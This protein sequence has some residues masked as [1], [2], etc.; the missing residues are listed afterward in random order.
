MFRTRLLSGIVLVII[1]AIMNICGGYVMG[2]VLIPVA[3]QGLFEFY[4]SVGVTSTDKGKHGVHEIIGYIGAVVYFIVSYVTDSR[5]LHMLFLVIVL[6][7]VS[8]LAVYVFS[9]PNING[10]TIM[11]A[12]YGFMYVPVMLWFIMLTRDLQG[13][14]FLV[15]LIY[16]SS[17]IRDTCAY[18]S[19]MLLGKHRLA[20][21]LSPKKSVEGAVGGVIG[22]A[23]VAA[24]YIYFV[25]NYSNMSINP[26]HAMI[27]C[28]LGAV[29][30]QIGDLSA[31]AFKRNNDIKDY[32][33]IIPG[34]GGILDRFDSVIFTA[35]MI[36]FLAAL[37]S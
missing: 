1:I 2:I 22:S 30:S 4:R 28:S 10:D 32:G 20:P 23:I 16:I 17:W 15:W 3:L 31:S 37:L 25:N 34:H 35:P 24:L 5:R 9:F 29:V 33:K 36:Y 21:I 12:F 11:K 8:M 27:I 13:G 19:G 14:E 26:I 18:C 6:V 7:F